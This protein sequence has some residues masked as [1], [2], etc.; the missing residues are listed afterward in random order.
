MPIG[1]FL[2]FA[3]IRANYAEA[4]VGF[5]WDAKL[6]L[7]Y[8][9]NSMGS[10]IA[11]VVSFDDSAP[12][13]VL[14]KRSKRFTRR[15][16]GVCS[17]RILLYLFAPRSTFKTMTTAKASMSFL[18]PGRDRRSYLVRLERPFQNGVCSSVIS[19]ESDAVLLQSW[20]QER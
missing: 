19:Q 3:A 12:K 14:G 6:D 9:P 17:L 11:A 7:R 5:S 16:L 4:R 10:P 2:N 1:S 15:S 20:A 8:Y 13:D 18:C